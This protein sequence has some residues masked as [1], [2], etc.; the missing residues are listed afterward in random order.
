MDMS[1]APIAAQIKPMNIINPTNIGVSTESIRISETKGNPQNK[2][3]LTDKQT[4]SQYNTRGMLFSF[5][6]RTIKV[7]DPINKNIVPKNKN[8]S[9]KG[10][11]DSYRNTSEK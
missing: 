6:N 8:K 4:E 3:V 10:I 11:P 1:A 2:K 7:I 5:M 9:P